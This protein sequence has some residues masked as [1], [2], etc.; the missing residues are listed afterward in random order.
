[1]NEVLNN[2]ASDDKTQVIFV[3]L[4][5]GIC[6]YIWAVWTGSEPGHIAEI[7]TGLFGVAVGKNLK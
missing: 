4:L 3:C 7:I 2:S 1:M 5:L 6:D